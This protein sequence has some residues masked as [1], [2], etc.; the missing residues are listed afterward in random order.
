MKMKCPKCG[1]EIPFYDLKPNCRHCGVNILYYTQD[2]E[3]ERDAKKTE[4]DNASTRMVIARIKA[5]FV[6]SFLA[7]LRMILLV[8][9]ICAMMIPFASITFT[10][11]FYKEK[12][13]LG[14]IGV[15]QS[16]S[17]GL[18]MALLNF[19]KSTLFSKAMLA[20]LIVFAFFALI[21]VID[22]AMLVI[23]LLSFLSPEKMTKALRNGSIV[24]C[25]LSA[26]AQIAA[27]VCKAGIVPSSEYASFALGF[28]GIACFAL[29]LILVIINVKMLKKGVEPVY[30]EFDP[31][32]KELKKKIKKGEVN[33]D[34]L[35]LPIF[36]SEEEHEARM[37]EFQQAMEEEA[38][39][40]LEAK[41][42]AEARAR[43]EEAN[44][45]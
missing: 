32:R 12:L 44:A 37:K 15:I 3:L 2:Y 25:V 38:A 22:V 39:A 28:G 40:E 24:A 35:P 11:P 23:Y 36:E 18:L 10:L 45:K 14:L 42:Q 1:A 26:G 29:H 33:L 13:S 41:S 8:G 9:A 21:A 27:I 43:E 7:I 20:T 34:D 16:F 31:K 30:R 6:G 5:V 17:N 19:F 4:L